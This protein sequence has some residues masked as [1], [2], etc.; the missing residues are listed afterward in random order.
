[1]GQKTCTRERKR[2]FF[3]TNYLENCT[4]GDIRVAIEY[5]LEK[6]FIHE[7]QVGNDW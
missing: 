7:A 3:R 2:E 6:G 1:M 5:L 4:R